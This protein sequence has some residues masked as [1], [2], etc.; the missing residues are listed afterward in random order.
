MSSNFGIKTKI[1]VDSSK[2]YPKS[3]HTSQE[4]LVSHH[5]MWNMI[6]ISML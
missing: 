4:Q 6:S 5:F 1:P 3:W 2:E